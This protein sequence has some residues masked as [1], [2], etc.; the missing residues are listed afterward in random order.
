MYSSAFGG[1]VC[2]SCSCVTLFDDAPWLNFG[3][4]VGPHIARFAAS[5]RGANVCEYHREAVDVSLSRAATPI[6]TS[7]VVIGLGSVLHQL[8]E[9]VSVRHCIKQPTTGRTSCHFNT[10]R[11]CPLN[12]TRLGVLTSRIRWPHA[13]GTR[14]TPPSPRSIVV[15]GSGVLGPARPLANQLLSQLSSSGARLDVRAL[16]G[17]LT[18]DYLTRRGLLESGQKERVVLGDPAMIL[19][20]MY[21]RC[22]RRCTPERALCVI[23]HKNDEL[24]LLANHS[25]RASLLPPSLS[26]GDVEVRKVSTPFATMLEWILGCGLVA[27]SSLHGLIF[28]DAFGVPARWLRLPGSGR[29]EGW[30]KYVDHYAATRPHLLHSYRSLAP[31]L[32]DATLVDPWPTSAV[33]GDCRPATSLHEA[34]DLGGAPLIKHFDA[35]SLLGAFPVEPNCDGA[36]VRVSRAAEAVG[37]SRSC[38]PAPVFNCTGE[39]DELRNGPAELERQKRE[40]FQRRRDRQ[41]LADRKATRSDA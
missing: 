8:A 29:S 14:S 5:L 37:T 38:L 27:S 11:Q 30:H 17:P 25:L 18:L 34:F 7:R 21:P 31:H 2:S 32:P 24:H 6:G 15:W 10:Q 33:L 40:A 4:I 13:T 3:D 9:C 16:R 1:C 36:T 41:E 22:H 23:P 26:S 28:A 35:T 20:L 39:P 19:P 12:Q